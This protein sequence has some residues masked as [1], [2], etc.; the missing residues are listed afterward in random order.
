[1]HAHNLEVVKMVKMPSDD[2]AYS[3]ILQTCFHLNGNTFFLSWKR[4]SANAFMEAALR[5]KFASWIDIPQQTAGEGRGL[6]QDSMGCCL[7]PL[8]PTRTSPESAHALV[9]SSEVLAAGVGNNTKK[10]IN[11][12]S[13]KLSQRLELI[14]IQCCY[15]CSKPSVSERCGPIEID[16]T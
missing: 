2:Q 13:A 1:M 12:R 15:Y 10:E 3:V 16:S 5:P 6:H 9:E 4:A 8:F 7:H 11:Q 14:H